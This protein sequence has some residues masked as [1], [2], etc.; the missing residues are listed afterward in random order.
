MSDTLNALVEMS[1][2]LGRPESDLAILGEGNTSTCAG[3]DAFWVKAS[4]TTLGAI[5]A[6]G[7]V[8]LD[9]PA[10]LA[11]LDD[12]LRT[13]ADIQQ[14]LLRVRRP[15]QTRQPSVEAIMHAF[16]LSI[17]GINFVGHTHPAPVN[18][19]LCSVNAEA[20]VTA[21]L[22][23]DQIVCCGP[24][25]VYIPYEDPGLPLARAVRDRVNAWMDANGMT[26][27]AIMIQNHGLFAQGATPKEVISCSLMWA[28]T[29]RVI[30]GA[31]ACGG[32][33]PLTQAQIERIATRP[34]EKYREKA[35]SGK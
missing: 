1:R 17:P 9:H 15:G 28:K 4:G 7:F 18:A 32:I 11:L 35:I 23:P 31:M 27:R 16:L 24:S 33:H 19:L 5:D 3:D 34:D 14:A 26:P 12:D 21:C 22:F 13:D 10:A 6:D 8:A 25:P 30:L 20:L 2:E 29:A